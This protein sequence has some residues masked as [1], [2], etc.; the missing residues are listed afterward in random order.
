MHTVLCPQVYPG[1]DPQLTGRKRGRGETESPQGFAARGL[2]TLRPPAPWGGPDGRGRGALLPR[3][4]CRL[5]AASAFLRHLAKRTGASGERKAMTCTGHSGA[6]H[7]KENRTSLKT[8]D[9]RQQEGRS[10]SRSHTPDLNCSPAGAASRVRLPPPGPRAPP[11]ALRTAPSTCLPSQ[12][13]GTS[14][15]P[16]REA[17]RREAPSSTELPINVAAEPG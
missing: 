8:Q 16:R 12:S 14:A 7:T 13:G 10:D 4:A 17:R 5:S 11:A 2:H 9:L 1:G 6:E 15:Q 3:Q